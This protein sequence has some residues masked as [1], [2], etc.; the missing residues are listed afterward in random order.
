[1]VVCKN[2]ASPH[3]EE[4]VSSAIGSITFDCAQPYEL[5]R[6]WTEVVGWPIHPENVPADDE[7]G[8]LP[9][10][11]HSEL[12]FIRVPEGKQVK[13][14]L[15]LDL[16]PKDRTRDAEVERLVALGARRVDDRRTPDGKGWVVL[17]DPEGNEFCVV[18]SAAEREGD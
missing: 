15:H 18:R 8:L 3:E 11:G 2:D 4:R 10:D 17:A 7:V 1:L 5:A 12:L 14:R 9:P 16:Q 6:F 13:N